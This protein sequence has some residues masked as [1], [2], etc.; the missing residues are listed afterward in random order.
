MSHP[1]RDA[2]PVQSPEPKDKLA[3]LEEGLEAMSNAAWDAVALV[4]RGVGTDT[5]VRLAEA[6]KLLHAVHFDVRSLR[7]M[8]E[9]RAHEREMVDIVSTAFSRGRKA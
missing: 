9:Q 2:E 6:A 4:A 1:Y 5:A 7:N 3:E 8:R